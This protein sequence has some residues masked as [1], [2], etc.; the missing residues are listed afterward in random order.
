[1]IIPRLRKSSFTVLSTWN[2]VYS[3]IIYS[4]VTYFSIGTTYFCPSLCIHYMPLFLMCKLLVVSNRLIMCHDYKYYLKN[5]WALV[6]YEDVYKSRDNFCQVLLSNTCDLTYLPEN[7]VQWYIVCCYVLIMF[8]QFCPYFIKA[9]WF[10]CTNVG[11][12]F[13][14]PYV[15]MIQLRSYLNCFIMVLKL[16][17]NAFKEFWRKITNMI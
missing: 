8:M 5:I 12:N 14:E 11:D 2:I 3:C 16:I 4:C 9:T 6:R 13:T 10:I 7:R 17:K 15:S 1:M